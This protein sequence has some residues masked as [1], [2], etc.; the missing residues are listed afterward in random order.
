MIDK[1]HYHF[2]SLIPCE[3]SQLEQHSWLNSLSH[4]LMHSYSCSNSQSQL[5]FWKKVQNFDMLVD[6]LPCP[7]AFISLSISSSHFPRRFYFLSCDIVKGHIKHIME[8]IYMRFLIL[9][10]TFR[11]GNPMRVVIY[12]WRDCLRT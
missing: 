4:S 10:N 9:K 1:W 11:Y 12:I 6:C 8:V 2:L 5:E 7:F 3:L